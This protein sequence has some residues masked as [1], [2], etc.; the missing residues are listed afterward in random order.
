[1]LA[2][3]S[4]PVVKSHVGNRLLHRR[5][6][7]IERI[8]FEHHVLVQM[9]DSGVVASLRYPSRADGNFNVCERNFVIFFDENRKPVFKLKI[10]RIKKIILRSL[11]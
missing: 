7:R 3:R 9:K 8:S 1:M 10:F 6:I 11:R 4:V 2:S 5:G